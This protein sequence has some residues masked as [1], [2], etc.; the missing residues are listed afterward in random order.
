MIKAL[1]DGEKITQTLDRIVA[2]F[3]LEGPINPASLEKLAYI[4]EYH[5]NEFFKYESKILSLMGLFFK[6]GKPLSFLEEIYSIFAW[7]IESESG[8]FFSPVQAS[9]LKA[10]KGNLCFSFSAPTSA[11]KSYLFRSLIKNAKNDVIIVVPSRALI[12]EYYAR[13]IEIVKSDKEVL[14]L[15]FID[16]V[17]TA[18]TMRRIF[19]ITPERGI[20]LFKRQ[21]EFRIELFLLDEAQISE[22]KN[23]GP[24]FDSFVRRIQRHFPMAKKV[25]A[26]PFVSNP[27]AQ[28]K[29]HSIE[30]DASAKSFTQHSVGKIYL[31][32][33]KGSFKYFSPHEESPEMPAP[34]DPIIDI[35]QSNGSVLIYTSKS[36][37][38]GG[39]YNVDFEKYI[40]ACPPITDRKALRL[41]KKLK[42]F[43]GAGNA[44]TEKKS[45]LI[46]LMKRGIVIHHGSI[47]LRARLLIEDFVR[48]GAAR[49]C[50]A[51]STLSQ[52]INMPFDA[53]WIDNFKD[54][55]TLG[56]KNLVGRA[57]R[58][59]KEQDTFDYGYAVVKRSNLDL[60]KERFKDSYSLSEISELDADTDNLDEDLK[61]EIEAVKNNS[62]DNDLHIPQ[63]QVDRLAQPE[64]EPEIKHIL[65]HLLKN[66][67]PLKGN[68]YY[69]LEELL[70]T[71]IKDSFKVIY[72]QHLRRKDLT[73]AEQ[74]VLSGAIPI[75]LWSIQGRSFSQIVS[76]RHAY[77]SQLTER[78]KIRS[79]LRKK[80]ISNLDA[81]KELSKMNVR[82]SQGPF[83]LPNKTQGTYSSFAGIKAEELPYDLVVYDTYDYLDKVIALSIIDPV[84]AAFELYY[85]KTADSRARTLAN[86]IRYGTD[87]SSEIMLMRYG[88][89]FEEIDWIKEHVRKIDTS[90]IEFKESVKSL[91]A[92]R[93]EL[94][95]RYL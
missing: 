76:L 26:H 61:D 78:R 72:L 80:I 88:F 54:L 9:A 51:T 15:Q 77:L 16:N 87:N 31:C 90:R 29:K 1:I 19:I 84:C 4:K 40:A 37:I 52:G 95:Q 79:S 35:I 83:F 63:V 89:S 13:V 85:R 21:H 81:E 6:P 68:Q 5:Q 28:L 46:E 27:E 73:A 92:D 33:S 86:Y 23:R 64:I 44:E 62:F 53:V 17:N 67:E 25:F 91:Q 58:A 41:I 7:S 69:Q 2:E 8:S 18:K 20:E 82:Y 32:H 48:L 3:H 45:E 75:L 94:L 57:G 50:F 93:L 65:D 38:Y 66:G 74:S 49:I 59:R 47:P 24:R 42:A 43:I 14:V 30:R 71:Q 22:D 11:G 55:D 36:K 70:R 12:A 60:F 39:K 56:L 10:I 34:N